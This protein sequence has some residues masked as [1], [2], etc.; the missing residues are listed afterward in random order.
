MDFKS[1]EHSVFPEVEKMAVAD[2]ERETETELRKKEMTPWEQ[3]SAVISIPRFDYNAPSSLLQHSHSGFLI[4]CPIK[5]EK[6]AT[7]EAI[8]LFAKYIQCFNSCN[9]EET[10]AS[11]RRK[12]SKENVDGECVNGEERQE[13]TASSCDANDGDVEEGPSSP[14][15]VD[16]DGDTGPLLKLVKLTKSGLLLFIFAKNISPN[17]VEIV[18]KIVRSVESGSSGS[19]LWCNR[20]F[21]IQA[22][23]SLNEKELREVVSKLV[24]QFLKDNQ[25]LVR[26]IKFAIGYNR[27]GIETELNILKEAPN[28]LDLLD[29]NKCFA[30]VASAVKDVVSDSVVDLKSPELS[31]LIE[32]LPL[33]GVPKGSLVVAVSVLPRNVV[34][35]K[36][37]LCIKALVSDTK[38]KSEKP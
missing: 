35:A 22:T 7:K 4:T 3:H 26:P 23:C 9:S 6:S 1:V 11:K 30:I 15:K 10:I 32:L 13:A 33:S 25:E 18:S 12:L 17:V 2:G 34:S 20:I 38:T 8:S 29:R 36:P 27:R 16:T 31:V 19:L 5:R 14:V 21:P 37:K 28:A 24:L